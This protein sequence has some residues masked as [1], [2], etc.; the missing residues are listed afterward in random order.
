LLTVKDGLLGVTLGYGRKPLLAFAWLFFFWGLGVAVFAVA[1]AQSAIKPN[2]PVILRSPEWILC[3]VPKGES[4]TLTAGP[5]IGRAMP[6]QSQLSCFLAQPEASSY[7]VF[8]AWMY[9]LDTL[10]PV[11]EIGQK[12][13]W[14]PDPSQRLG[15]GIMGYFYVQAIVGW[16]LSLLAIAGFSG[17]VKSR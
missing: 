5:A 15:S 9:S 3:G 6:G 16:A 17:L 2:S 11:L 4:L 7:P 10:F 1:Q 8:N 13:Y 14:R 12:E